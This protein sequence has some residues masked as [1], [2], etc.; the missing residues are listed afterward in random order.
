M[1]CLMTSRG[2][3]VGCIEPMKVKPSE[4]YLVTLIVYMRRIIEA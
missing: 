1:K 4:I 2:R 3:G